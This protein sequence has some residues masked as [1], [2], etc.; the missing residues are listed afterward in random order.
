VGGG[1]GGGG[2][3]IRGRVGRLRR[4]SRRVGTNTLPVSADSI[5]TAQVFTTIHATV[6]SSFTHV[7]GFA[8]VYIRRSDYQ[9]T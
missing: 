1:G 4:P 6:R 9:L 2:R 7:H 3:R 5:Y 8:V